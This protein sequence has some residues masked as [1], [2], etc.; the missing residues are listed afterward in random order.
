MTA[1]LSG[2]QKKF[3][4]IIVNI[5]WI[6][7]FISI[8][9][10]VEIIALQIDKVFFSLTKSSI[11][12]FWLYY[13]KACNEFAGP[14]LGGIAPEMNIATFEEMSQRWQAVGNSVSNLNGLR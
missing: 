5:F 14:I 11:R 1:T 3:R 7:N 12:L 10:L 6:K 13:V 9:L 8:G 2:H 4:D